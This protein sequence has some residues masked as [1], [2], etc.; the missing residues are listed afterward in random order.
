MN[1]PDNPVECLDQRKVM[2]RSSVCSCFRIKKGIL[3]KRISFHS[4]IDNEK[5]YKNNKDRRVYLLD[6]RVT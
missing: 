1:K 6:L 3:L 2:K 4:T 5:Q